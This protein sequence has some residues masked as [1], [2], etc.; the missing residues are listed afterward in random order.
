M[1]T[2]RTA[3]V[4]DWESD[5]REIESWYR[6]RLQSTPPPVGLTWNP[7][8]IGPTWSWD[9]GWILP[10]R[11]LGWRFLAWCGV[12]LKDKNG[13]DWQFTPEQARFLLWFYSL[14]DTGRW[15]FESAVLQRLKGWGKDPILA[16]VSAGA[17]FA[18]IKFSH[19]DD[20]TPVGALDPAGWVQLI[21]VSQQQTQN[22]M[23]LFPSLFKRETI[24]HFGIQIGRLNVWGL[25]DTV[26]I[27]AI[28]SNFLS[29]EGGRPTL[30]GRNETQNWNSS[31]QGHEMA[32]A[33]EGNVAKSERGT[34]R[35]LDVCNAFRPGEDSVGERARDGWETAQ[36]AGINIGVM[37]DSLEAPP[38]APLTIEAA[39]SVLRSIAGDSY[40][41]DVEP[42]G[43]IVK[44]IANPQNSPSE[45]R[46]KWY[47]QITATADAWVDPKWWDVLSSDV[48]PA[49]G[50]SVVLFFDGGK[51]D[52]STALVG[53]TDAGDVFTVKIWQKPPKWD[54]KTKGPWLVD[55]SDVDQTVRAAIAGWD[56]VG[57]WGDPSD[58]RDDESGERYWETLL[59]EWAVLLNKPLLPAVKE[60]P[61][62]HAVIWDMRSPSHQ[63]QFVE[64][65]ERFVT[66]VKESAEAQVK[67][68]E[69]RVQ[70]PELEP[71]VLTIRHDGHKLT[72][73]HVKNARRRPNKYG[74]SLGK[75]HRESKKKV[76]A[77]VCAVGARLMWRMWKSSNAKK[78]NG[79]V[80]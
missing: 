36:S 71:P 56:V 34:A 47:N 9:S 28:T 25:G 26:Q 70:Q 52:D 10:E 46:R 78:R 42:E 58:A 40:W 35:I 39:P 20:E 68:V 13:D 24:D 45:S 62:K 74:V 27:E 32:G 33:I 19:W 48:Q 66:D 55:R 6:R 4:H 65:A 37:Y 8:T 31:N 17:C 14:D 1:A 49:E 3:V 12:W 30:V 60:G 38:E 77:A 61:S 50:E 67:F 29:V 57:F 76:D 51:S 53:C 79:K 7:I 5:Y 41:L 75:E 63:K 80:W 18:P 15:L 16:T 73:A 64:A 22:T 44:S 21:A 72:A 54:D 59:D 11:T 2:A 43:R 23:K 69:L